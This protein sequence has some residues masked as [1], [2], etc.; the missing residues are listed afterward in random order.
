MCTLDLF[1]K[2]KTGK[3]FS[4]KPIVAFTNTTVFILD[5]FIIV[6]S[7]FLSWTWKVAHI[8]LI[9]YWEAQ[10]IPDC[11]RYIIGVFCYNF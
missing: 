5:F 9:S 2:T 1:K 11:I 10:T 8:D 4:E 6:W 3:K 7:H